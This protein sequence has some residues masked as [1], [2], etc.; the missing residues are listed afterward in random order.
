MS[1][2]CKIL[3][4]HLFSTQYRV[5]CKISLHEASEFEGSLKLEATGYP[6]AYVAAKLALGH[7]LV[8]LRKVPS[9]GAKGR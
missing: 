2:I 7:D 9:S 8:Q 1:C 6:L 5:I 3:F 4:L